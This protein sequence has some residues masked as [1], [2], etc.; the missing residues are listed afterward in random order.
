MARTQQQIRAALENCTVAP[1]EAAAAVIIDAAKSLPEKSRYRQKE[2]ED[3]RY[4][5]HLRGANVED[6]A[7]TV[8]GSPGA[9]VKQLKRTTAK[10][11]SAPSVC[12]TAR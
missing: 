3:A 9:S 8:T 10:R 5:L 4:E 2:D 12:S 6:E 7:S 1:R 11:S